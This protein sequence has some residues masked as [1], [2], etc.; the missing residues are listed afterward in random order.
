MGGNVVKR[1]RTKT[2]AFIIA[3]SLILIGCA[4][5]AAA[6]SVTKTIGGLPS[7]SAVQ[8]SQINANTQDNTTEQSEAVSN[9]Q[10]QNSE[11]NHSSQSGSAPLQAEQ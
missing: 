4:N 1:T 10:K 8:S 6:I 7:S 11:S 3:M 9:S 2:G 5:D